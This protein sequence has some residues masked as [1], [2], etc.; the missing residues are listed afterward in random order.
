MPRRCQSGR[1]SR[2]A[3]FTAAL[4]L[5]GT[6]CTQA[7]TRAADE[8]AIRDLDAQWSKASMAHSLDSTVSYYADTA[9]L[10]P[11]NAPL[12]TT[13]EAIRASWAPL[14]AQNAATSWQSTKVEVA[15]SGDLAYSIGTYNLV[16]N[17][18]KAK[19][20]TDHGKFVEVWK[21]QP[22]GKW[23]VAADIYNSSVP[24]APPPASKKAKKSTR[25]KTS[26]KKA[27]K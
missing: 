13:R 12:A 9:S 17:G 7:D 3:F 11:P 2:L 15:R 6:A 19:V 8:A 26:K 23:K 18:P 4:A 1:V 20:T 24:N 22:D 21:K 10:L 27:K 25:A 16:I 5:C 14:V